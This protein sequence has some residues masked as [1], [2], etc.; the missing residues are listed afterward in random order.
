ML[1]LIFG[2][3]MEART[4][5]FPAAMGSLAILFNP[6]DADRAVMLSGSLLMS[7]TTWVLY[8]FSGG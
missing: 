4:L 6:R 5:A 7:V 3:G 8:Y 1:A 2:F